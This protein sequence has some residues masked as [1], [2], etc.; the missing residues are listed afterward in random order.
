[1]H[2][3]ELAMF[4]EGPEKGIFGRER[5]ENVGCVKAE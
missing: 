4:V 3:D 5:V 1:V 2:G